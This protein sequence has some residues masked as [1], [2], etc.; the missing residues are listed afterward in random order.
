MK[1]SWFS[2]KKFWQL[3]LPILS[4]K[5]FD[6][7]FLQK[8]NFEGSFWGQCLGR[9]IFFSKI[10]KKIIKGLIKHCSGCF[11]KQH[12]SFFTPA[13]ILLHRFHTQLHSPLCPFYL[14][15]NLLRILLAN[16]FY[17]LFWQKNNFAWSCWGKRMWRQD[18]FLKIPKN[19]W[20]RALKNMVPVISWSSSG[21]FP[22]IQLFFYIDIILSSMHPCALYLPPPLCP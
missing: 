16:F 5:F 17:K 4:S 9:I 18:F 10:S 22:N 14:K 12:G 20:D 2:K 7:V 8:N 11:L 15:K 13:N 6:N 21:L 3:F 19:F 1:K